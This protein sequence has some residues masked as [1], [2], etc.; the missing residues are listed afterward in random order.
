MISDKQELHIYITGE[1]KFIEVLL[2]AMRNGTNE[3]NKL[4]VDIPEDHIEATE[5]YTE[6]LGFMYEQLRLWGEFDWE[7]GND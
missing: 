4:S 2:N 3:L 7:R 5:F 6:R 1:I